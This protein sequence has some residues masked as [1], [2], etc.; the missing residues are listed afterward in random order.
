VTLEEQFDDVVV[1]WNGVGN[2]SIE[3]DA[4]RTIEQ[5]R[6]VEGAQSLLDIGG[7][8]SLYP[9]LCAA[10]GARVV[11]LDNLAM[12]RPDVR[13]SVRERLGAF[14]VELVMRDALETPLPFPD[15]T[16]DA[17]V[18][19]DA[20][21]H[22]HHSP[23]RLVQEVRRVGRAGGRF[24]LGVP[25]AVNARKRLAV[26]MGRT[27]WSRFDD[28]YEPDEFHGHVR[29]PTV[30]DVARIAVDLGLEDWRIVGRNWLG[31]RGGPIKRVVT[32]LV[33]RPLRLRPSLCANI[34]LLGRLAAHG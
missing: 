18:S 33:D 28:W 22:F 9:A 16:F 8:P 7:G 27:N 25:N 29:E 6:W 21:E 20:M 11:V 4:P 26:L 10:R 24:V 1:R 23:K 19:F 17:V 13:E 2:K 3:L 5:A 15:D 32:N 34:Y 31:H 14:G 30:G 12:Y